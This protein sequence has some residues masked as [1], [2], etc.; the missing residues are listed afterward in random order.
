MVKKWQIHL[1]TMRDGAIGGNFFFLVTTKRC[2][3]ESYL[4]LF[5]SEFGSKSLEYEK[6]MKS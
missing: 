3:K 2:A 6:K 4:R 1:K 5:D